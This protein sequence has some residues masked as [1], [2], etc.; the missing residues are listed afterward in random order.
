MP[1][2]RLFF[3]SVGLALR[4]LRLGKPARSV[5]GHPAQESKRGAEA[6]RFTPSSFSLVG[7]AW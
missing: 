4:E 6:S 3:S 5:S 2:A 7:L 1:S